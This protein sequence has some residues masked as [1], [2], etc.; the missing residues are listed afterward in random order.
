MQLKEQRILDLKSKIEKLKKEQQELTSE[1]NSLKI[2]CNG[3]FGKLGSRYSVF[4][5]PD[6]LCQVTLTG[7]LSLLM[8]IEMLEL[9]G[10]SVISANTDGIVIK[11]KNELKDLYLSIV[12]DWERIT[13]FVTEESKYR[14][15]HSRDVNNY[16][17]ITIE[18]EI[19]A[20]GVYTNELSFKDKNRESLM[21]NPNGVIVTEAVMMF[22]KTCRSQK[23]IT[24]DET[25]TK[26]KDIRKFLFVRRVKGGAEKDGVYLGKVVRWYIKKGEFGEI[27]NASQNAAG[28]KATVSET[29]GG[30]PLMD[31]VDFPKDIDYSWYIRR[32]HG[33]LADIG[34]YD[35]GV[36]QLELFD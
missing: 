34:Y 31:I 33:I 11:C 6:L 17:A 26:C 35:K 3:C 15:I 7:Q 4:Y 28:I 30:K 19:K 27:R 25:I 36:R 12:A 32:A 21:S 10:I 13:N 20:K 24:I 1:S 14:S 22:L 23:P 5:S 2:A 16:V 18:G 8:L 29:V 9:N